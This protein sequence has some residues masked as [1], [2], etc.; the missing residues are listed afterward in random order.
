MDGPSRTINPVCV[1]SR[2]ARASKG[3]GK[4]PVEF[5]PYYKTL[6]SE[7]VGTYCREWPAG[8]ANAEVQMIVDA[9][10]KPHDIVIYT[11]GSVTR[12]QSGWGFTIKQAGRTAHGDNGAHR[13]T[14]SSLTIEIEAV[15]NV[16]QWLVSQRD[17][18]TTHAIILTDSVN[19][20]QKVESG[21]GCPDWHTAMHS[22]RL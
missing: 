1:Q 19:L 16:V 10:S 9:N 8:E 2:R 12:D 7:N 11:D 5:K 14:T 4:R 6:L 22:L 15:T 17:A 13:A 18:Q 3:L 20:L 21:M